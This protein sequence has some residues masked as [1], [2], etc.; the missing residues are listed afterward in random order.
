MSAN[1]HS[2]AKNFAMFF[3]HWQHLHFK[4]GGPPVLLGQ[5]DEEIRDLTELERFFESEL[6]AISPQQL[7]GPDV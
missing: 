6:A 7:S 5:M 3:Q 4:R 2:I 1:V